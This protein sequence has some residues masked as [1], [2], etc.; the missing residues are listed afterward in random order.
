MNQQFMSTFST[1]RRSR[2]EDFKKVQ[3]ENLYNNTFPDDIQILEM[4]LKPVQFQVRT[5]NGFSDLQ[6]MSSS[7]GSLKRDL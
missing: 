1:A 2:D 3:V 7:R 5:R 6:K 4:T